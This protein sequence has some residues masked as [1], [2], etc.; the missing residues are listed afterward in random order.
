HVATWF[1]GAPNGLPHMGG[2]L[3][4]RAPDLARVGYL[5]LRKGKWEDKQ[6]VSES[7]LR[8]STAHHVRNPRTFGS[9][10]L[11]YG[12]LW[13]LLPLNNVSS[14]G[15]ENDIITASGA[16]GQWLFVVP[17]LDLVVAATSNGAGY[18]GYIDPV[19]F[20]Y[21]YILPAIRE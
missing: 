5:V 21:S 9:H 8:E 1:K 15:W 14:T 20:L 19:D 12:Y 17:S 18:Q 13:W 7:W 2:G 10:P 3:N 16:R 4:L 6:I 11:D